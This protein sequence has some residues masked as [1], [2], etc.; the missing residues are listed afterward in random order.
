[1]CNYNIAFLNNATLFYR[2]LLDFFS[3]TK[4]SG[5]KTTKTMTSFFGTIIRE[6]N[7][8]LLRQWFDLGVTFITDLMNSN[9]KFLI[10]E[11]F[12]NK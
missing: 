3:R 7:S 6:T 9:G 11:K 12:Q 2:E 1:M 10:L 5:E 4:F 8:V